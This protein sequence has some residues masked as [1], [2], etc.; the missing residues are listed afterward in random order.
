MNSR[1]ALGIFSGFTLFLVPLNLSLL[2]PLAFISLLIFIN[3]YSL[4]NISFSLR[5]LL[6]SFIFLIFF[7]ILFFKLN[8]LDIILKFIVY[9]A[10]ML[11]AL[12]VRVEKKFMQGLV[13]VIF[14]VFII[15]CFFNMYTLATAND[16]LGRRVDFRSNDLLP[17]VGGIYGFSFIS[18]AISL[19]ALIASLYLK[20]RFITTMVLIFMPLTG[21]LRSLVLLAATLIGM[22]CAYFI[23]S[24]FLFFILALICGGSILTGIFIF[25]DVSSNAIRIL[26]LTFGAQEIFV[27]PIF[28][29]IGYEI[30]Q[31]EAGVTSIGIEELMAAGNSEQQFL[32]IGIHF[33]IPTMTIFMLL[34]YFLSPKYKKFKGKD[35]EFFIKRVIVFLVTIDIMIAHLFTFFPFTVFV[36]LIL[37]SLYERN[38]VIDEK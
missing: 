5:F 16:L 35:N 38:H 37:I 2:M 32:N 12:I 8:D 31:Y 33:G 25:S 24:R 3:R 4:A 18:T 21:G 20:N 6:I 13:H 30:T 14:F 23:K 10:A 1:Y 22:I 27:S 19:M 7:N 34:I 15:D 11:L 28:G 17:R 26:A 29:N 36:L 9:P